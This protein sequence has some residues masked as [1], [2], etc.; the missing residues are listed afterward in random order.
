MLKKYSIFLFPAAGVLL[1]VFLC[2]KAAGSLNPMFYVN[3]YM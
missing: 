1:A 3:K 2:A